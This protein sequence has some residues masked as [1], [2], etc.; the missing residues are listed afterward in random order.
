MKKKI[1]IITLALLMLCG[2]TKRFTLENKE[3]ETKKNYVSNILCKPES[4]DLQKIYFENKSELLVDYDKLPQCKNLKINSG[5]Y[6][7]LWTTLF[8][9]PLAWVIVKI[10]LLVK[11]NGLAIMIV[12]LILRAALLP[13]SLKSA[14]MNENL[15]KAQKDLEKLERKYKGKEDKD[16]MMLKSQEMLMI[17]KKYNINPM[18]SCLFAFLQLP[19]FFAFLEAVYRVPAFFE[20][21]FLVFNLGTTPLEG[22]LNGNYWYLI[23]LALIVL[24]TYFSFKNMNTASGDEMQQKQ[25]KMMSTFMMIFICIASFSLPTSIALYWIVSSGFTV[26]QNLIVKRGK[27]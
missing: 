17:Y 14:N 4:E 10:G 15:Q 13:L 1:L 23:L 24:T 8:V 26:V 5:G 3:T 16:S 22:I 20:N 2:C 25:M 21:N 7:G 19:I 11:N 9:K 18:S 12:G 6:E 27:M